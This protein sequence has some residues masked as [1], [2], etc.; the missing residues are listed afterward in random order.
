MVITDTLLDAFDKVSMDII[1]PLPM[2]NSGNKYI[3]TIQDQ[4]TKYS[5]AVPLMQAKISKE[6]AKAF[7]YRFIYHFGRNFD[8]PR[9]KFYQYC[10]EKICE[11]FQNKTISNNSFSL[12][13][14]WRER[15]HHVLTEY[16]KH[17]ANKCDWDNWLE[18]CFHIIVAHMKEQN[19]LFTNQYTVEQLDYLRNQNQTILWGHTTIM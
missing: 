15:S 5:V 8:G 7:I 11:V 2:T 4:L 1:R 13:I 16:L 10:N 14:Q 6:I 17:I 18:L 19:L 3:L 12:S 9:H